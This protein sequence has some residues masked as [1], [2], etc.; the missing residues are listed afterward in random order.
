VVRYRLADRPTWFA[1]PFSTS[2]VGG[3]VQKKGEAMELIEL[4]QRWEHVGEKVTWYAEWRYKTEEDAEGII[5]HLRG[6]CHFFDRLKDGI[7][8][9]HGWRIT[10]WPFR[11]E[12]IDPA[13]N[14]GRTGT[15]ASVSSYLPEYAINIG[16]V[17]IVQKC[18]EQ[19]PYVDT[20]P[21]VEF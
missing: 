19:F 15:I 13:E 5:V 11:L 9:D 4:L 3:P 16:V 12:G 2:A 6:Q 10:D 7:L 21:F 1:H 18:Y 17:E 8:R 20:T 14:S